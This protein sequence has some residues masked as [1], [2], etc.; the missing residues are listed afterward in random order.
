MKPSIT[1][2]KI[3]GHAATGQ[4]AN[5]RYLSE[6]ELHRHGQFTPLAPPQRKELTGKNRRCFIL[7]IIVR[8]IRWR[9]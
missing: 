6:T 7:I 9:R 1:V 4:T 5:L 3:T 2:S 8:V